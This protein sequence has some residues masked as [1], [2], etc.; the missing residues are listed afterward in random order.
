[1]L[2]HKFDIG[3]EEISVTNVWKLCIVNFAISCVCCSRLTLVARAKFSSSFVSRINRVGIGNF[4]EE[5]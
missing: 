1:M 4:S 2:I 5:K 3:R